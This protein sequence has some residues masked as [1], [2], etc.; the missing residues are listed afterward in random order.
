MFQEINPHFLDAITLMKV[1]KKM[2]PPTKETE[3]GLYTSEWTNSNF[4]YMGR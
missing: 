1:M 2:D 3:V 4:I